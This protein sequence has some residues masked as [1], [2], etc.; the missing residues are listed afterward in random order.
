MAVETQLVIVC[1][2]VAG[3]VAV[4]PCGTLNGVAYAPAVVVQPVLSASTVALLEDAA[5][6]FDYA[7]AS[8]F[9]ALGVAPVLALYWV[10]WG[11]GQ[12][13][14]QARTI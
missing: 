2:V 12:V 8:G 1:A 14:R 6:P 13:L 10:C 5:A 7:E 4:A 11:I 9:W 3:G